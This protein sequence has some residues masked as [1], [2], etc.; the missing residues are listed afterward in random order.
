[1]L[2]EPRNLYPTTWWTQFRILAWRA[3]LAYTRNPADVA[4]RM[5]MAQGVAIMDGVVIMSG[6][7]HGD[8]QSG[9]PR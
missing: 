5:M 4:G 9:L 7:N 2:S 8:T 3:L 6:G 1:M